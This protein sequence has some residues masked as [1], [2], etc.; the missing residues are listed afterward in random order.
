M[1]GMEFFVSR[2]SLHVSE[3]LVLPCILRHI[4]VPE[5]GD[6]LDWKG[7]QATTKHSTSMICLGV[8]GFQLTRP[9]PPGMVFTSFIFLFLSL[10]V[11]DY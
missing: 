4:S 10:V 3:R 5:A 1:Q 7:A 8:W 2:F 11:S 9:T 6:V